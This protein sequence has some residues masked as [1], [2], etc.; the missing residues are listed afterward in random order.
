M[1]CDNPVNQGGPFLKVDLF[2][3]KEGVLRVAFVKEVFVPN[4]IVTVD[5]CDL[6]QEGL[7]VP[8][9]FLCTLENMWI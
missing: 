8:L 7:N 4:A 9:D 1:D 3:V 2:I 5:G 6:V